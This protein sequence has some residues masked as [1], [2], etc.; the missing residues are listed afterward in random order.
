VYEC[1]ELVPPIRP[2]VDWYE[3]GLCGRPI[4]LLLD[5]LDIVGRD[6]FARLFNWTDVLIQVIF[7]G[8]HKET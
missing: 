8:K 5:R 4:F 7:F 2:V 6:Y 3:P 1:V